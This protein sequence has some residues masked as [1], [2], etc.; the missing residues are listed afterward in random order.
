MK[1]L[2]QARDWRAAVEVFRALRDAAAGRGGCSVAA[3]TTLMSVLE[4]CRLRDKARLVFESM[5]ADGVEPT[6]I[7][8]NVLLASH[9]QSKAYSR[10]AELFAELQRRG[11]APDGATWGLLVEALALGTGGLADAEEALERM[12]AAGHRPDNFL[13]SR[14]VTGLTRARRPT[15][16]LTVFESMARWCCRPNAA[17]YTAAICACGSRW[18]RALELLR[19]MLG[20]GL[21]P[22]AQTWV[23]LIA[24]CARAGQPRIAAEVYTMARASGCS[25]NAAVHTA[26]MEAC[27]QAGDWR[28]A[29]AVYSGMQSDGVTPNEVSRATLQKAYMRAGQLDAL[30]AAFNHTINAGAAPTLAEWST[31]IHALGS[32][33]RWREAADAFERMREAGVQPSVATYTSLVKTYGNA[34]RWQD[35]SAMFNEM[36]AAG[37]KSK[38]FDEA[39]QAFEATKDKYHILPDKYTYTALLWACGFCNKWKLAGPVLSEMKRSG[40][41]PDGVT[42]TTLINTYEKNGRWDE[43]MDILEKMQT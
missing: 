37:I 41:V 26:A 22:A 38:M 4:K 15:E 1:R 43:A 21:A 12:A 8:Y 14:L 29:E 30:E 5:T 25:T 24:T 17:S 35:A 10:V 31:R 3:Y 7:S 33:G 6:T 40:C 20:D 19:R 39:M 16:A 32:A 42:Y 27:A 23:A 28:G 2:G 11:P 34:G 9:L 13:L 18:E 36:V